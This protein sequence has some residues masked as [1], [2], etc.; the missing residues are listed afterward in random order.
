[1][2]AKEGEESVNSLLTKKLV[3]FVKGL[4]PARPITAG[5]NEPNSGNHLFRSG[6][7]DVIGYNYH[8]KDIPNVPANFPA[9]YHY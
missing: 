2:L 4:D 7:L 5:C 8:N 9:V 6:V 1:M 3:S